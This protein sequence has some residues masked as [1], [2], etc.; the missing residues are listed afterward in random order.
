MSP[1]RLARAAQHA[2]AR[3]L[4]GLA[5]EI[6]QAAREIADFDLFHLMVYHAGED[7][8]M[9]F[10]LFGNRETTW[11]GER[12]EPRE[13]LGDSLALKLRRTVDQDSLPL[14]YGDAFNPFPSQLYVPILLRHGPFGAEN[15]QPLIDPADPSLANRESQ[16]ENRDPLPPFEDIEPIG[17]MGL[18][19]GAYDFFT[20][21]HRQAYESLGCAAAPLVG[22]CLSPVWT[23]RTLI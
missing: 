23:D 22:H 7:R 3:D 2:E 16:I 6:Y 9:N 4:W 19:S 14:P 11:P 18:L 12:Q 13:V 15:R 20:P 21:S 1:D 10:V 17:V 8:P 5:T